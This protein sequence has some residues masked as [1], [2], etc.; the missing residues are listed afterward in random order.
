MREMKDS[1]IEWIG[2]IPAHWA[3][4]KV[5]MFY[6]I[7]LGKMLQSEQSSDSDTYEKYLCAMN[8]G[9]NALKYDVLKKMWFSEKERQQYKV[10]KGDLIVVE[11]GDVASCDI[12]KEDVSDLYIQNALHRVR[13]K[14]D[15]TLEFLRYSLMMAKAQGYISSTLYSN[16]V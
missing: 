9:N 8:L 2:K 7:V 1:G 11:G 16:L 13:A 10:Q 15:F 5:G 14:K 3:L 12:V 4:S 6:N